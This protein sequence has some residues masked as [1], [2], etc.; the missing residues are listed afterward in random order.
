MGVVIVLKEVFPCYFYD[1]QSRRF[2]RGFRR[3][4]ER[5]L[6]APYEDSRDINWVHDIDL[7]FVPTK[8]ISLFF[9]ESK[10]LPETHILFVDAL[11]QYHSY[12]KVDQLILSQFF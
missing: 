12:S 8:G 3:R 5:I 2:G 1:V 4:G 6:F 7:I 9:L 11:L 10:K